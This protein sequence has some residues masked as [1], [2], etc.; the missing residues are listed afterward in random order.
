MTDMRTPRVS[1]RVRAARYSVGLLLGITL[2]ISSIV[3]MHSSTLFDLLASTFASIGGATTTVFFM[4]NG[5]LTL[6]P[7]ATTSI[8]INVNTRVPINALGATISFP[9]DTLEVVSISKEKSF[10]NLWTEDTSIDE[11]TGEIHFSGGTTR[12]GGIMGTGTMLTLV[13]RAKAPGAA[14]LQ[15]EDVQVFPNNDT[16]KPLDTE[17]RTVSYVVTGQKPL[18]GGGAPGTAATTVS[19]PSPDL[20]GDGVINLVD[21]SILI[22]KMLSSYNPRYDLNMNGSVGLDDLSILLSKI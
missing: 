17:T 7:G 18:A 8:D 13:V 3:V 22:F 9:K 5:D 14:E 21:L 16:G 4:P 10:F 15:F 20:N 6:L 19:P 1:S 2:G 11:D 12:P